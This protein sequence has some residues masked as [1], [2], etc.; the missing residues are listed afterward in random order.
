LAKLVEFVS[1]L[2]LSGSK[3]DRE[4]GII[5][6]VSVCSIGEAR[7]HNQFVDKTTLEQVRDCAKEYASG[8]KVKF[9]PSSFDHGAAGIAGFIPNDSYRIKSGRLVGDLHVYEKYPDREYLFEIAEKSPDHFGLSMEFSGVPEDKDGQ[10][11]AR[12]EEIFAVA[13]VDLPAA[14]PT[15]LF[16]TKE[17]EGQVMPN[18]TAEDIK[19]LSK[20]IGDAV[21]EG[22]KP[23]LVQFRA[24]QD[25]PNTG[26]PT[27]EERDAAGVLDSDSDDD[28]Q[29]KIQLWRKKADKPVTTRD[30]MRFFRS[31][32]GKPA[33]VSIAEG[34]GEDK[35][36]ETPFQERVSKY[37]AAGMSQGKAILRAKTDDPAG[38]NEFRANPNA[39]KKDAAKKE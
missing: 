24:N 18:L 29:K 6:G 9:N 28:A 7:G 3:V 27:D 25:N 33:R 21:V 10:Q 31:T 13:V 8:L 37:T 39:S 5:S 4:K 30:L 1:R 35:G 36:K 19:N 11:F 20:G 12:C 38:Y 22:L 34:E 23:V 32:G 26:D 17:D 2:D 16:K 15:G 14:N